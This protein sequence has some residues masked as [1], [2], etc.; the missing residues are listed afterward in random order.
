MKW[1]KVRYRIVNLWLCRKRGHD[2][3]SDQVAFAFYEPDRYVD[4]EIVRGDSYEWKTI[5]CFTCHP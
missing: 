4:G 5:R 3:R 2:V 1:L